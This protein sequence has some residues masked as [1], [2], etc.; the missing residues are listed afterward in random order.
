MTASDVTNIT[1]DPET[2]HHGYYR[3]PRRTTTISAQAAANAVTKAT[4][5]AIARYS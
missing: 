1:L 5:D 2:H 3:P 4:A